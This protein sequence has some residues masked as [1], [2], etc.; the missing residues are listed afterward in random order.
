M[1]SSCLFLML[2]FNDPTQMA[3]F[4][5]ACWFLGARGWHWT[6]QH[7]P[8]TLP[9]HRGNYCFSCGKFPAHS[10]FRT[11]TSKFTELNFVRMKSPNSSSRSP[12]AMVSRTASASTLWFWDSCILPIV[13]TVAFKGLWFK[14]SSGSWR[15]IFYPKKYGLWAG[16]SDKLSTGL[17]KLHSGWLEALRCTVGDR[18]VESC[19]HSSNSFAEKNVVWCDVIL[20]SMTMDLTPF[21]PW[22]VVQPEA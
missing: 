7:G 12:G 1:V 11:R 4:L 21:K 22:V 8:T 13:N 20:D 19:A 14:V 9:V 15:M 6:N 2:R 5:L 16:T 18:M 17:S 10:C 3:T